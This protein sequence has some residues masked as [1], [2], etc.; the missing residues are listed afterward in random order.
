METLRNIAMLNAFFRRDKN[1]FL[2]EHLH[3]FQFFIAVACIQQISQELEHKQ[4]LFFQ[5][6]NGVPASSYEVKVQLQTYH[7]KEG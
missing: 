6:R 7:G 1:I 3:K 2:S 4:C 5:H